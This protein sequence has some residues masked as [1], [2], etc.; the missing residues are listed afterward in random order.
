MQNEYSTVMNCRLADELQMLQKR[1]WIVGSLN[2]KWW[3]QGDELQVP[4]EYA[5]ALCKGKLQFLHV[6][7]VTCYSPGEAQNPETT[8]GFQ[9][10]FEPKTSI[11]SDPCNYSTVPFLATR[12]TFLRISVSTGTV[13]LHA[14]ILLCSST[15]SSHSSWGHRMT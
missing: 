5:T 15:N 8:C 12:Q 4:D 2:C 7:A 14:T 13:L 10:M 1:W 11:R 6:E 3:R 9:L